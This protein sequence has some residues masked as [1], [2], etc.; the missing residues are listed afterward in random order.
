MCQ[1]VWGPKN[2]G[3]ADFCNLDIENDSEKCEKYPLLY[4]YLLRA[5]IG[6]S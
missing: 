3:T 6:F 5:K 4:Y 1:A 2:F